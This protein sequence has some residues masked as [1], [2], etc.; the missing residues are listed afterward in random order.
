MTTGV[1]VLNL[2]PTSPSQSLRMANSPM[3]GARE[4]ESSDVHLAVKKGVEC[5]S[6]TADVI[7]TRSE[8][9]EV[10]AWAAWGGR[11]PSHTE[12]MVLLAGFCMVHLGHSQGPDGPLARPA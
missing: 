7:S 8:S 3:A 9:L 10:A 4:L 5:G 11:G 6:K 12:Q 1:L 2:N